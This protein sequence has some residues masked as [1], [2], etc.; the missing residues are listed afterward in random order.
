MSRAHGAQ[1]LPSVEKTFLNVT[2][3]ILRYFSFSV[4]VDQRLQ[5]RRHQLHRPGL[6]F[7]RTKPL[8]ANENTAKVPGYA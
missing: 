5:V 3:L 1:E 2:C 8:S 6:S 7:W 4:L